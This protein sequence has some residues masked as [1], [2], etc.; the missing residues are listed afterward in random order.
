MENNKNTTEKMNNNIN[1]REL[2]LKAQNAIKNARIDKYMDDRE[3]IAKDK[4]TFWGAITG[5]NTLQLQRIEN[6]K[7]RI[8]LIQTQRIK[9]PKDYN[10]TEM[11]ADLYSCAISELNGKF[12]NEMKKIYD[13]IKEK[14]EEECMADEEIFKLV[15]EKVDK[16]QSYLPSLHMEKTKGILGDIKIQIKFWKQENKKLQDQIVIERGRCQFE[17]FKKNIIPIEK[18]TTN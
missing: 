5:R 1:K 2:Y 14:Y 10:A 15:C 9:E 17:T 8:E 11:L 3:I 12:T 7:L 18:V 16:G 6:I 4:L 13:E